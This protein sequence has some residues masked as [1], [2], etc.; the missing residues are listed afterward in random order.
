[1]KPP[2]GANSSVRPN[3]LLSPCRQFTPNTEEGHAL[4]TKFASQTV[5]CLQ[6]FA[7]AVIKSK[8][9]TSVAYPAEKATDN[10]T[11]RFLWEG[12]A[13]YGVVSFYCM[14]GRDMYAVIRKFDICEENYFKHQEI[15]IKISHIIPVKMSDLVLV[16]PVSDIYTKVFRVHDF[17]CEDLNCY[18]QKL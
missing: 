14:R 11:V 7:R 4:M 5:P 13:A 9:C 6:Y 3:E 16:V 18:E 17:V 1:M 2:E 8:T 12:S 15:D 10:K